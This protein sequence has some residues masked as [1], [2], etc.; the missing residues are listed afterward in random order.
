M[1]DFIGYIEALALRS[2]QPAERQGHAPA[3]ADPAFN[4][5]LREALAGEHE[6]A[7]IIGFWR[8]AGPARWFAKEPKFDRVFRE[9]F[10]GSHEAAACG[11][12]LHWTASP[13]K[14]L[15]LLLLLDQFPRNAF[16]GTPRMY[17]TDALA[18]GVARA[19]VDAAY[20]LK[21]PADLRLFFYLPFAHSENLAHQ[22]RS[23]A[24][25]RRLGEPSLSH[26]KGHR[27]IIRRFGR[28]PHR[29]QILGRASSEEEQRFL[30]EGG[31]AG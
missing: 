15:A 26:A 9:G 16:R 23:V 2:L 12:L 7:A 24:L 3:P 4:T 22:E 19:A 18:L 30:D 14:T 21:G 1:S 6:A 31:F 27:D 13:E 5:R 28:F 8:K 20:D 17:A 11:E 29:N 25:A 10:L